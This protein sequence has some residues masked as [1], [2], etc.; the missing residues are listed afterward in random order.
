M[1]MYERTAAHDDI[2]ARQTIGRGDDVSSYMKKDVKRELRELVHVL[3]MSAFPAVR[4]IC[5]GDS[6][7]I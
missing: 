3:F 7:A 6:R 2:R 5:P 4:G 1:D